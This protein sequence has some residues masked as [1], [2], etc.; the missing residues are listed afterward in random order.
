MIRIALMDSPLPLVSYIRKQLVHRGYTITTQLNEADV[1]ISAPLNLASEGPEA[2]LEW[3]SFLPT[4]K[5]SLQQLI[6]ISSAEVYGEGDFVCGDCGPFSDVHR[7]PEDLKRRRWELF[8]PI[9]E[10]MMLPVQLTEDSPAQP[11]TVAGQYYRQYETTLLALQEELSYPVTVLRLFHPYWPELSFLNAPQPDAIARFSQAFLA[12]VPPELDEDG[13][14]MR[15]ITYG[16]D[17][18]N[19]LQHAIES[20]QQASVI[21]NV[22]SGDQVHLQDIIAHLQ[23]YFGRTEIEYRLT[24][25]HRDGRVRHRLASIEKAKQLWG[26]QPQYPPLAGLLDFAQVIK[27]IPELRLEQA[28]R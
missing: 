24:E 2:T 21:A 11:V 8:C 3:L 13:N 10:E 17:I 5:L 6:F 7:K 27:T 28:Q 22:G 19:C 23:E 18:I 9:C 4:R 14:Q 20:P 15:D 16:P 1:L 25:Q 12:G 26:Y